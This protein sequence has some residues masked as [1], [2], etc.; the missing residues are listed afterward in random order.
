MKKEEILD[1]IRQTAK[2]N[3]GKPLGVRKFE[4]VTGIGES[5]WGEHWARFS[6]AQR[7]ARCTPNQMSVAYTAEDLLEAYVGLARELEVN[8]LPTESELRLKR[9]QDSEF[10]CEKVFRSLGD[11]A[12][13]VARLL[14]FCQG[15]DGYEDI[16]QLCESYVAKPQR[17]PGES[18]RPREAEIGFVYLLKS[19]R[20]YYVGK[21]NH[22]GRREYERRVRRPESVERVHEIQTVDPDGVEAY[23][24]KRFESERVERR[25]RSW[26]KL[27]AAQVAEFKRWVRI[28]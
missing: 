26:Y 19:G 15:R 16:V 23:W 27:S 18:N 20:F 5:V 6:G 13:L 11:K 21:T 10:P 4:S 7:E 9:R 8:R 2:E 25:R 1:L 28:A 3:G 14:V 12:T 24:H 17:E 22:T